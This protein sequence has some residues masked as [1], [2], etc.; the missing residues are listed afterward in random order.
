M[1]IVRVGVI[2]DGSFL[3]WGFS[4]WELSGGNHL[5]GNFPGGSFPS[6]IPAGS[7]KKRETSDNYTKNRLSLVTKIDAKKTSY[8]VK[9]IHCEIPKF[10]S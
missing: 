7:L 9:S 5:G 8:I 1:E 2:L 6:T 10:K 4:G 3:W